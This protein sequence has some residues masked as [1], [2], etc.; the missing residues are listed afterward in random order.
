MLA[1]T[2]WEIHPSTRYRGHG[3]L[4]LTWN[5]GHSDDPTLGL[6]YATELTDSSSTRDES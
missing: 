2:V 5:S 3:H 4:I 1:M 6:E